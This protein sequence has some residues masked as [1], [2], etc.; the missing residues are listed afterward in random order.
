MVNR[1]GGVLAA[2]LTMATLP[3][4]LAWPPALPLPAAFL[5]LFAVS[6]P[7]LSRFVLRER[8]PGFLAY[9]TAVHLLAHAALVG[10]AAVGWVRAALDSSFGPSHRAAARRRAVDPSKGW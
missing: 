10:G 7:S 4:G 2:A 3:L 1:A 8:G 6:D 5:V 9:F